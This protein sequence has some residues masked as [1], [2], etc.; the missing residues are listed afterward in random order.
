MK[1]LII[2]SLV[3]CLCNIGVG[4]TPSFAQV[5]TR[6]QEGYGSLL[7]DGKIKY[8]EFYIIDLKIDTTAKKIIS[9]DYISKSRLHNTKIICDVIAKLISVDW[10]EAF[11]YNRILIPVFY[12][13]NFDGGIIEEQ[14]IELKY[15]LN[16][17]P[18]EGYL[19]YVYPTI[20]IQ[21][22]KNVR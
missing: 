19:Q 13:P 21:G 6:I 11:N 12:F 7:K 5:T 9:T 10:K 3:L 4:Q 18:H 15:G 17:M 20:V 2:S 8:S 1:K 22:F 16:K 14:P